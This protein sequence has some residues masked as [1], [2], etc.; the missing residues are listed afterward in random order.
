M[1][2]EQ[3][4]NE[5]LYNELRFNLCEVGLAVSSWDNLTDSEHEAWNKTANDITAGN[6]L[7]AH[8]KL[9]GHTTR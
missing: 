1:T 4:Y 5:L 9:P 6:N 3:L 2:G 7:I 8:G